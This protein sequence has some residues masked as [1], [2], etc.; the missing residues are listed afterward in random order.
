MRPHIAA[1]QRFGATVGSGLQFGFRGGFLVKQS[2]TIGDRDLII[3]GM[4]FV[5][6]EKAVAIAAVI[7][8]GRLQRRLNA[9]H[10]REVDVAAQK[11]ASSTFEI[12][13]LYPAVALDHDPSLLGM[14][15]INKHFCI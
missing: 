11:L 10:F 5:E 9:C 6:R 15:G 4:D 14:R 2:L 1:R 13:L 7:H 8:E 3:V 12:E